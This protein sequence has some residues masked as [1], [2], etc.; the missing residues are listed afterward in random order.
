LTRSRRP[1]P[2]ASGADEPASGAATRAPT[3]TPSLTELLSDWYWEQD[4]QFR[5]TFVSS[6]LG[7]KTGLD[8]ASY[9]GR[10]R[11]EHP[12]L[13][14]TETDWDRHR[15]QLERHQPFRDFEIALIAGKGRTVWISVSGEPLFGDAGSFRGYRGV[16]RDIT[17]QKRVEELLRLEHAVARSLA[18]AATISE[19]LQGGLRAICEVEG[20]DYGRC[21]RV[22]PASLAV[23]FEE[24]WSAREPAIGQFLQRSRMLWQAG[25][26]VWST[27]LP[28][29]PGAMGRPG[30]GGYATFAFPAVAQ[31]KTIAMLA[32]SGHSAREPDQSLLDAT[33][34]I[35]SLFA[36]FLRRME[37]ED[38]LRE[39]EARFRSLTHMSSD[40]F[41]ETDAQHRISSIVHGPSYAA[42]QVGRGAIGQTPWGIPSARPDQAG[43][44]AHK[45]TLDNQLPFRDFEFARTM[46]DG[47]TRYFM[48]SGQP[49]FSKDG[50]FLGYRGVGRDVTEIARARE[51]IASLAYSDALTGLANRTSLTPALE[52]AIERARRHSS[53]LAGVF[54]DLD[55]FKQIND[56]H[57]HAAGDAFLIEVGRR[58]R[59]SLR[60]SDLVARLGGDEFFVVLEEMQDKAAVERI[61]AKLVAELLRP[62]DLHGGAK[63]RVS[64]SLGVSF[65]PDDAADPTTLMEHADKAMYTAK[66]AGKNAYCLYSGGKLLVPTP[67]VQ[68]APGNSPP[69]PQG[70]KAE[71]MAPG[72]PRFGALPQ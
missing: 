4:D 45:A 65:Y 3:L 13:N 37:A 30:D 16:G 39:S 64:A 44:A 43:W 32:F 50:S 35:G 23:S 61:L 36:Q 59:R 25:K 38:S 55:G 57:G 26:P 7:E 34:A 52:Q 68:G 20:W 8:A 29:A 72:D 67:P 19:G 69:N 17:A 24:G 14:L 1:P 27:D 51:R 42:A 48:V 40:F 70:P 2:S 58:L 54:I 71:R 49:Q 56:V 41:W 6:G 10:K 11:W 47:G 31:G 21:F 66:Q 5:F 33:P 63:A 46:P 28:R 53:R 62:Y 12:A 18:Q 9:L 22:D 15:A 60:A